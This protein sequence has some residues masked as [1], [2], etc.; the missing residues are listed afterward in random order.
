MFVNRLK[1]LLEYYI[2]SRYVTSIDEVDFVLVTDVVKPML[3]ADYYDHVLAVENTLD[4]GWVPHDKLAV[5]ISRIALHRCLVLL[6]SI[7]RQ[8]KL[9]INR[10]ITQHVLIYQQTSLTNRNADVFIVIAGCICY[11]PHRSKPSGEGASR[12]SFTGTRYFNSQTK[13]RLRYLR[14]R[15]LVQLGLQIR[16]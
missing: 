5:H 11:C 6:Q 14:M 15:T 9:C 16:H 1:T 13:P 10:N 7:A 8:R 2:A 3:P 12:R 4:R